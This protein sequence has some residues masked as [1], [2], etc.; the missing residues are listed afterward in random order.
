MYKLIASDLDETLLGTDHRICQRNLEAIR[1]AREQGV[2]FVAA[3][4]RGHRS[5]SRELAALDLLDVP[6]EYAI[7]FNGG[8]LASNVGPTPIQSV[9]LSWEHADELWRYGTA[10]GLCMHVYTIDDVVYVRNYVDED[11]AYVG[12]RM[13]VI[14]TYERD[15]GFLQ[16]TSLVKVLFM[17]LDPARLRAIHEDLGD[18]VADLDVSYSARRYIEF[19]PAGVNK[20]AGLLSLAAHLGIDPSE[21]IAIGDGPNDIPMISAAGLGAC[22]ANAYDEVKEASSY[23]CEADNNEGGVA[24]VI[25]CFVLGC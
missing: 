25:E 17:D 14:E 8:V 24:E 4:G 1:A 10:K 16:G 7:A 18:R 5:I 12:D 13:H 20:G 2:R 3:S 21:T 22:V 23:I 19:N 6:G 15:L 11:R 9:T